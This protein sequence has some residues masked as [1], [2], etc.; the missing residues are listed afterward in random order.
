MSNSCKMQLKAYLQ[1]IRS[2]EEFLEDPKDS[3]MLELS[4]SPSVEEKC[5]VFRTTYTTCKFDSM[6]M[7]SRF[8][9]NRAL[10]TA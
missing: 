2:T 10:R 4:K 5:K 3:R 6:D 8:R 7:T 1:C 9:G